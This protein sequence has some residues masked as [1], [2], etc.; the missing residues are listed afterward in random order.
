VLVVVPPLERGLLEVWEG[1]ALSGAAR[2]W[3]VWVRELQG[4]GRLPPSLRAGRLA[5]YWAER[6]GAANVTVLVR[7]PRATPGDLSPLEVDVVRRVNAVLLLH[8]DQAGRAELSARL[9]G[10]LSGLGRRIGVPG[11]ATLRVPP[12]Q[13]R[14]LATTSS[15]IADE[16]QRAGYPVD[17]DL[18]SLR[19]RPPAPGDVHSLDPREVLALMAALVLPRTGPAR[20]GG[21]A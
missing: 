15:R 16:V 7:D 13:G 12:T 20:S 8:R 6:V 19:P 1:R 11:P 14:W 4:S 17:G 18:A 2:R 10:G 5:A 21:A 3:E 9:A